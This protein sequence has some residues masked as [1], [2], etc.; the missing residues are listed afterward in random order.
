MSP[1]RSEYKD[2]GLELV[3]LED[4]NSR[5]PKRPLMEGEKKDDGTGDP[6]KL[7][8]EESLTQQRNEMMDSFAQILRQLPTGD[9]SSSNGGA[10]PLKVQ[11]NFDIPIFEGH[12]DADVVDKWLNLL[13]GYFFFHNFSN[14]ENITF[15]SSKSFPMSKIGGKHSVSK[16][17]QR[18]PNYFQSRPPGNPSGMLLRNNT[19]L[20]KVMTTCIPNGPHCSKK[21]TKKCQ[22]S[23]ISS[24]PCAPS[25][26]SN[27][28]SDI[29]CSSIMFLSIDTS[30]LKWNFWTSHP[31]AWPTDMSSKSSRSSNKRHG[32]LGLGTPH[33]K[34]QERAATT[35]KTKNR[36]KMDS[37]KTTSPSRKQRRTPER[38]R[39][40]PGIG[41]TSIRALGIT[42]LTAAQSSRW[43]LK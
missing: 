38:Q 8:I 31:W 27:I 23:Q 20:S 9:A 19:T 32:Y 24:I 26:V 33:N 35:H 22:I 12:I 5:T 14:R 4:K 43:W 11:I 16:R 39:K 36:A 10:T 28:W 13:E 17:K 41:A 34:S 2:L 42:L 30:R 3:S 7:L 40:T 25:W 37:I 15:D 21:E 18:N 29:W 1:T 6:F